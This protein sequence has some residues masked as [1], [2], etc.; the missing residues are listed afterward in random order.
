MTDISLG[1]QRY[2]KNLRFTITES[3]VKVV[4]L[5][6]PIKI[7]FDVYDIDRS[8]IGDVVLE[9]DENGFIVSYFTDEESPFDTNCLSCIL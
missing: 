2:I 1:F 8:L 3:E 9:Q 7:I 5:T 6:D 4:K